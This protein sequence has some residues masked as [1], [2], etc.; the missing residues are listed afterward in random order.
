ML[1]NIKKLVSLVLVFVL[2]VVVSSP[3][4][5]RKLIPIIKTA[6]RSL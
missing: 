1:R 3:A 2:S 5:G 4:F 6:A